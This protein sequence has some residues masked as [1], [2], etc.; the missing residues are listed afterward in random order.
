METVTD[1]SYGVIPV[2]R[3]G[4]MWKVFLIHQYGSAGDVYWTFPKGH[5]E[6]EES[7]EQ[8]AV[9]ELKEE[10]GID[11]ASL[12]TSKV[13]PQTYSF[14]SADTMVEKYVGYYLGVVENNQFS[15]Q[16]NEV[17]EA[18]WFTFDEARALLTFDHARTL[19]IEVE[20]DLKIFGPKT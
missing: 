12:H 18:G 4:D 14:M 5:V 6:G 19:L 3:F 13:Y 20:A 2:C 1:S 17:K 11:L 16:E 9:R 7:P 10:T 8:A 15:I